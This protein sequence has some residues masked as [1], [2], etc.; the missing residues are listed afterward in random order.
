MRGEVSESRHRGHVVQVGPHGEVQRVL[1]DPTTLVTLRSCV[2][3]FSLVALIESGAA[4]DL[5]LTAAELAVMA[6][7]HTGE[8]KH[9]RTLQAVF[10]RAGVSQAQLECGTRGAPLDERT[11]L[12]LA[13]DGEAPSPIR[14]N[15]SGYHAASILLSRFAGWP[16]EGYTDPDHQSQLAVRE[17]VARL[18]GRKPAALVAATDDCG[19]PTY[20]VPLVEVARAYLLLADPDGSALD[21]GRARSAPALRRI[22]DAMMDNPDLVGGTFEVA[23]TELMRRRPGLLVS[24]GGA[25]GLRG[26]GLVAGPGARGTV[27]A[28]LALRIEDGDG[29]GRASK[30]ATLEALA[31]MGALDER[32]LRDLARLHRPVGLAPNGREAVRVVPRFELAPLHELI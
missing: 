15:C 1:G 24:K 30:A 4:D 10:R 22:R 21:A 28:G 14:H 11:A 23:D 17:T 16:V 27:P 18:F 25:E 26:V 6:G 20:A 3:P 32:D 19:L 7:S 12:R 8:D 13:R 29:P 2:K 31:R 9:V 5:G